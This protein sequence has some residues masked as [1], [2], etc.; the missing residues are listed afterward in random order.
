M[1]KSEKNCEQIHESRHTSSTGM[2]RQMGPRN[3]TDTFS[4]TDLSILKSVVSETFNDF[5]AIVLTDHTSMFIQPLSRTHKTRTLVPYAAL[6]S[7]LL[8]SGPDSKWLSIGIG[9]IVKRNTN[10]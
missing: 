1:H 9:R 8:E 10:L 4:K 3:F 2:L 5:I 7:P 6:L